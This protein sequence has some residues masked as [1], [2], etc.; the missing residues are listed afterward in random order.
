MELANAARSCGLMILPCVKIAIGDILL[1]H[2]DMALRNVSMG[3]MGAVACRSFP[4]YK[5]IRLECTPKFTYLAVPAPGCSCTWPEAWSSMLQ[6]MFPLYIKL[7][8]SD[9]YTG[10]QGWYRCCSP[11][12]Q[13]LFLAAIAMTVWLA[14]GAEWCNAPVMST[15]SHYS[16]PSPCVS[17]PA[18]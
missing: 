11:D 4:S 2:F 10:W 1:S 13:F 3:L 16:I 8:P 6:S 15:L 7:A 17:S 18:N 5:I 12:V 9:P 14:P